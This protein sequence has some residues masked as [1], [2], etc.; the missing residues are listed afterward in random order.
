MRRSFFTFYVL[1]CAISWGIWAPLWLPYFGFRELYTLPY[2]HA[3][4]GLGPLLAAVWML[5]VERREVEKKWKH[6]TAVP[7][8]W[9]MLLAFFSPFILL[10]LAYFVV[11]R[12]LSMDWHALLT[13]SEFPRMTFIG[14]FFFNLLFFGIGEEGGWCGYATPKL[15]RRYAFVQAALFL[16]LFWALWHLPLFFFRP[17]YMQMSFMGIAGWVVSLALGRVLTNWFYQ[18]GS[19]SIWAAAIFHSTVDMAFMNQAANS[20]VVGMLGMFLTIWGAIVSIYYLN[21]RRSHSRHSA[22]R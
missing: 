1:A 9:V 18:A 7:S 15:R 20:Q 16:T 4:G 8:L 11:H 19:N 21:R 6:F 10:M 14:S 13:P 12:S 3:L 22:I 5:V 17:T 2:Q